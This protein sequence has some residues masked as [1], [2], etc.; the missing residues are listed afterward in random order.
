MVTGNSSGDLE[1][2]VMPRRGFLRKALGVTGGLALAVLGIDCGGRPVLRTS[3]GDEK[4]QA[5][6][7]SGESPGKDDL[8]KYIFSDGKE[9]SLSDLQQMFIDDF[10]DYEKYSAFDRTVSAFD[11]NA[12]TSILAEHAYYCR[13][14]LIQE[15]EQRG[16][17]SKDRHMLKL[18]SDRYT[19]LVLWSLA[20]ISYRDFIK[21]SKNKKLEHLAAM[22]IVEFMTR[23]SRV[24]K[25]R[26]L[27]EG[28]YVEETGDR[29]RGEFSPYKRSISA[30][31]NQHNLVD[32]YE[33]VKESKKPFGRVAGVAGFLWD[34]IDPHDEFKEAGRKMSLPLTPYGELYRNT[35]SIYE[36]NYL[37]EK[38]AEL[39]D[40]RVPDHHKSLVE[41]L[42]EHTIGFSE[43]IKDKEGKV[44]EGKHNFSLYLDD[45]RTEVARYNNSLASL[46]PKDFVHMRQLYTLLRLAV[47]DDYEKSVKEQLGDILLD[48]STGLSWME[49]KEAERYKSD[50]TLELANAHIAAAFVLATNP[51]D[52]EYFGD[53]FSKSLKLT[54]KQVDKEEIMNAYVSEFFPYYLR[55]ADSQ[56]A[57]G[58][59]TNSLIVGGYVSGFSSLLSEGG[60]VTVGGVVQTF[61]RTGGPLP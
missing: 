58:F 60:K 46:K 11:E 45:V 36:G 31:L 17:L 41:L 12:K 15:I 21:A 61:S 2:K 24:K 42:N 48:L 16:F 26:E 4:A 1:N 59:F 50:G 51:Y 20:S 54:E 8:K 25:K 56:R 57:E 22:D 44:V 39:W 27:F 33:E 32:A 49:Y 13:Q 52:K 47:E 29:E 9:Y 28:R 5:T 19:C 14:A 55:K 37:K 38:H 23:D 34:A 18:L 35:L 30:V 43:P 7:G 10:M 6:A 3:S 40:T 53:L